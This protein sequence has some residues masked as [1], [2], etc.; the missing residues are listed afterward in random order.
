M[1]RRA[2]L[3]FALI[4]VLPG[5]EDGASTIEVSPLPRLEDA[6]DKTLAAGPAR[7]TAA[8]RAGGVSYRLRGRWDPSGGYR[9]CAAI[10]DAPTRYLERRVLWL[11]GRN[12]TYG[13]LTAAGRT[14]RPGH[15]W[16][17]DHPPSLDLFDIEPRP[18]GGRAGAEDYLHATLLAL[19]GMSGPA[20]V[21]ESGAP[22]GGS[23]CYRALIDFGAFNRAPPRRDEDGWTLRP[24]LRR[25]AVR[26]VA[27]RAGQHGYVDRL[28]LE[29]PRLSRRSPGPVR[30]E[31]SLAGFGKAKRVPYVQAF[32]IE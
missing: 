9:V 27:A 31:L 15:T 32:A 13:T 3:P 23:R 12:R 30:V 28:R 14:C 10:D 11:E 6:V 4:A 8:I 2:L 5:C 7:F 22:C 18:L 16:F 19:G 24:L 25:L 20:L 17:D 21:R 26:A 29:V 1:L